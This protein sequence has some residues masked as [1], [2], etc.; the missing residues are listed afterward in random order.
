V[1]LPPGGK[2][3]TLRDKIGVVAVADEDPDLHLPVIKCRQGSATVSAPS[4]VAEVWRHRPGHLSYKAMADM[5]KN[6]AV[7]GLCASEKDHRA[8]WLVKSVT[9]ASGRSKWHRAIPNLRHRWAVH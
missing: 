2:S 9:S 1:T 7:K 3:L 5:V 8:C 4:S 6:S